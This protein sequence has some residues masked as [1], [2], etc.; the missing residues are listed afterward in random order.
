MK[1]RKL[2]THYDREIIAHHLNAGLS[3]SG[4]ARLI[5]RDRSVVWREVRRNKGQLHPYVAAKA[6]HFSTRRAKR[7]TWSKLTQ[8]PRLWQYVERRLRTGWSPE[9]IAGRL[10][11]HPP[12][13]LGG[14]TISYEAIY[15]HIYTHAPHLY[16]YLRKQH[17]TRRKPRSR[18]SQVTIPDR[19]SIW[20][21]P[22][23]VT[24]RV[25]PGHLETDLMFG[26]RA[27]TALSVQVERVT[28]VLSLARLDRHTAAENLEALKHTV[29]TLPTGFVK[30]VTFDN[31]SENVHHR[32]LTDEYG[33]STYFCD[34]YKGWQKGTVE[35][36][37]G[38]LREYIP[39]GCDLTQLDQVT[40]YRI[41]ETL[42]NRPR[43]QL[44]YQTP[45]E[46]L[47]THLNQWQNV[48]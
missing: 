44:N 48:A 6:H 13:S 15:Q 23:V 47:Q 26:R 12:P 39:K 29:E 17:P 9:Q 8:H 40:L 21:R 43:K 45:N 11:N 19:V 34:T 10:K 36:S 14:L 27:T 5:N 38:L 42:N 20:E 24:E 18:Q 7:N 32:T 25:E 35:N 33:V 31:G 16:H 2:L 46:A 41:Q 28:K 1:K 22:A 4:I 37:I 3:I 30:S